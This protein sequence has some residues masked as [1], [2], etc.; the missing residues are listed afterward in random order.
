MTAHKICLSPTPLQ[1]ELL[2]RHV[3]YARVAHNFA[4]EVFERELAHDNFLN[5]KSLR[6]IW[7]A[8]KDTVAPWHND[9]KNGKKIL[10]E[11]AGKNAIIDLGKGIEA[12]RKKKKNKT[13]RAPGFPRFRKRGGSGDGFRFTNGRGTVKTDGKR[14][15]IPGVGR[16]RMTESLRFEEPLVAEA[17]VTRRGG[18]WFVS[19]I[20]E[21]AEPAKPDLSARPAVAIDAGERTLATVRDRETGEIFK[22]K[23]PR[24]LERTLAK[25]RWA[26]KAV[27]RR[28]KGSKRRERAKL[29]VARIHYRIACI[30][31]D[32]IHKATSA[33]ARLAGRIVVEALDVAR[34]AKRRRK[35]NA[36]GLYDASMAEFLRVLKYKAARA[37]IEVVEVDAAYTSKTCSVCGAV[38]HALKS[39]ERWTCPQCGERHHRDENAAVVIDQRDKSNTTGSSPGVARGDSVRRSLAAA[40]VGTRREADEARKHLRELETGRE[41]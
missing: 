16:V 31:Q 4:R 11:L 40:T 25:L 41:V 2:A 18:K 39:A 14:V 27:S 21:V 30:R 3:G 32:Y 17:T 6:P 7:N 1:A 9:K 26:Q 28:K 13:G 33:I 20:C 19:F 12:W 34:M 35:R 8:V 23:H 10:N 36:R 38:N 37:G 24:A 22:L 29:R 15:H 5:D